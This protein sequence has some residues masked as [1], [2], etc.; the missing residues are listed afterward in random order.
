[1]EKITLFQPRHNNAPQE[2]KGNIYLPSSLIVVAARLLKAGVDLDIQDGNFRPLSTENSNIGINVVG[3]PYIPIIIEINNR[4]KKTLGRDAKTILGGRVISGLS[5]DQFATLFGAGVYNGNDDNVLKKQLGLELR[6]L[7]APDET[8]QISA[9]E[10]ISDA[11]F[12]E[13]LSHEFCLYLS[14]GCKYACE[15]CA[16]DHT[17]RDPETGKSTPVKERYRNL[18]VV[19]D[20]LKYMLDRAKRLNI[21]GFEIYLSNLDLFQTPQKLRQFAEII[22]ALKKSNPGFEIIMRG[23]STAKAFM[24]TYRKD[25]SIIGKMADAGLWSIGFGVDGISKQVWKSIKKGHNQKDECIDAIRLT[26]EEFNIM[27]EVFMVVGHSEDTPETMDEDIDFLLDMS[28]KFQAPPR[29]YV[30]KNT[31]PGNAGW[32]NPANKD[33]VEKF[34]RHPEYFQVLDYA[35]LPSS[36]THPDPQMRLHIEKAYK[37]M[38]SIPGNTTNIIYPLFPDIDERTSEIHRRLNLGKT[39]R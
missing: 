23:L 8:S 17:A 39:D 2:G 7:P 10:K 19:E 14:Q 20:E 9:Y 21:R 30:A 38:T 4:I 36:L 13:Y 5:K 3:A 12:Y 24:E 32:S 29:P 28:E 26:R 1:M 18:S 11:N 6:S 34:I 16:A 37:M 25:K 15:F 33:T 27:P 35:A 31:I 22:I